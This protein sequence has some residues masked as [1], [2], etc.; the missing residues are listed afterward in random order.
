MSVIIKLTFPAGCYHA[1]PWGRHVNEGVP[2]WPPSPWRLLRA[3]VAVWKRTC[4]Q[5]SENQVRRILEALATPPRFQLPPHRVAHTRH[6]MPWE[7]KGPADRTLV[8]DTFVSISRNDPLLIGWPDAEMS[9]D[10]RA[11]LSKLLTNLSSLGRAESWVHAELLDA[12]VDLHLGPAEASDLNPVPV[13][14]PDPATAFDDEHYPILD[15]TKLSSGR[16][17]PSDFL[18]DCPRWHLCLDTETVHSKRWPTIPGSKWVNY[19]RPKE[20]IVTPA[21]SRQMDRCIQTVARFRLDAPVLPLVTE[22]LPIGEQARRSLLSKCKYLALRGNPPLRDAE[23]WPLCPAFWGKDEQAQPRIGHQHA[24]FLPADEDNDGRLDHVTVFAPMGF[25]S[26]ERDAIYRLRRLPFGA[27]DPLQLLLIGLGNAQDFCAPLLDESAVWVSATPFVVTRYPKLRGTKRDRPEDYASPRE[28]A[29]HVLRQE[30]ARRPNLPEVISI[31][32]EELIGTHGLRLIQFKRFRGKSSDDG[33]RR[34]AGG[35][36][37]TFVAPV[38]GPLCLGHS[39]HF[40]LGL[41]VPPNQ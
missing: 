22:T 34:P 18:F 3:L 17:N 29:R 9:A 15:R 19:Q 27:G 39:C 10:D 7:K 24:F 5:V 25:N 28:F 35:F 8:F 13:F 6:Y 37:I 23:I 36:R 12:V 16:L 32:H 40:G 38:R 33:G 2:E 31:E 1:T 20:A 26:R 4:R 14:C 41:F 11:V 21:T 30:L